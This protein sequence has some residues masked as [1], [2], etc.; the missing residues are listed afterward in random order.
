MAQAIGLIE[1]TSIAKGIETADAMIKSAQIDI[2]EAKP[3][4]PG[5]YIVLVC[6]DVSAVDNSIS[7]GNEIG[8]HAV[9][10]SFILP[11]IHPQV[12][13]A[14][15]SASEVLELKALGVIETFSVAALIVSADTA[16]KAGQVDLIE[17]RIGMGIGGKSFVTLT[18]D[19]SSVTSSVEV[20]AASASEKGMLV[21]S[22]V[23]PS[24]NK[25]LKECIL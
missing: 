17:I 15:S 22:V 10:D 14:I 13:K 4:C 5:K 6:G 18:G 2:L 21:E 20:G 23:I 24:P 3:I 11:N 8:D 16:A 19:V 9:I 12:I 25:Q 1:L 7:V